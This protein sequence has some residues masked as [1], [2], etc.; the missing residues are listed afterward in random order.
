MMD[1]RLLRELRVMF[2]T[3]VGLAAALNCYLGGGDE[4]VED[5]SR[6]AQICR[7]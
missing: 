2:G 4:Q 6:A 7:R 5:E 1:E 3:M